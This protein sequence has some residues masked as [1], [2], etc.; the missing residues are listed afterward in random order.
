MRLHHRESKEAQSF[1]LRCSIRGFPGTT[2]DAE[3]SELKLLWTDSSGP[4]GRC[5]DG[6]G[7]ESKSRPSGVTCRDLRTE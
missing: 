7:L 4:N 3:V 2:H 5:V 6:A 1:E